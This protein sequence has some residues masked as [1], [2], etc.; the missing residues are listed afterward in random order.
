MVLFSIK[1]D[2][3]IFLFRGML[4]VLV[5]LD[6]YIIDYKILFDCLFLWVGFKNIVLKWFVFCFFDWY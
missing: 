4:M 6:L 1:N 3:Y 5:L 2:I